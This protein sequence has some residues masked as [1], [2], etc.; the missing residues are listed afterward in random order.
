MC[1]PQTLRSTRATLTPSAFCWT[2]TSKLYVGCAEDYLLLV[3]TE[4][5]SVSIIS[6]LTSK[7]TWQRLECHW[8][9]FCEASHYLLLFS[10][11]YRS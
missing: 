2:D 1:S 6:N 8:R 4:S 11:P 5:F 3:D 7:L 10:C 9:H